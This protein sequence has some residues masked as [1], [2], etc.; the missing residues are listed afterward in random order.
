MILICPN[1][2]CKAHLDI[3]KDMFG[4]TVRC[5]QCQKTIALKTY[6]PATKITKPVVNAELQ[7]RKMIAFFKALLDGNSTSVNSLL[8]F[9]PKLAFIKDTKG[10]HPAH[11]AASKGYVEIMEILLSKGADIESID[12]EKRTPMHYAAEA[13]SKPMVQF[14]LAKGALATAEDKNRK[15][16]KD[17]ANMNG[18]GEIIEIIKENSR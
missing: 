9:S 14:L 12:K 18:H 4:K 11:V 17:M 16:P 5:P 10:R 3:K 13:G 8:S 2:E 15:T 1:A 7:R 6:K